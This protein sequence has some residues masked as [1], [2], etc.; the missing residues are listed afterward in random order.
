MAYREM[1]PKMGINMI[2]TVGGAALYRPL[3]STCI[4]T[5]VG[6]LLNSASHIR[7]K[8]I[9][10]DGPLRG[11]SGNKDLYSVFVSISNVEYGRKIRALQ[12]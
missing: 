11:P 9:V 8:C 10:R 4:A 12:I 7:N 2:G 3:K 1:A 5:G 6:I